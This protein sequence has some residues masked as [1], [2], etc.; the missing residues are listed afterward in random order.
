MKNHYQK[1]LTFLLMVFFTS[2]L[3]A[4]TYVK[5]DASGANDGSSWDNA[6]TSFS[7]ALANTTTGEIWVASGTY[8]P[9]GLS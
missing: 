5:Q 6:Y 3:S 9:G 4:Q 1:I 2:T 8:T 7:D